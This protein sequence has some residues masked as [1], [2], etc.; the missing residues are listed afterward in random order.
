MRIHYLRHEE[1]LF[2]P[3]RLRV[4]FMVESEGGFPHLRWLHLTLSVW[5]DTDMNLALSFMLFLKFPL[6]ITAC[7]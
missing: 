2:G 3:C 6:F 7:F 5:A 1:K 4:E